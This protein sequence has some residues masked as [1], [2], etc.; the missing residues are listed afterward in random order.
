MSEKKS[1]IEHIWSDVRPEFEGESYE[2]VSGSVA[3]V[4]IVRDAP[5][6]YV[7]KIPSDM[8]P[9]HRQLSLAEAR[10]CDVLGDIAEEPLFG[11]PELYKFNQDPLYA[12]LKYVPGD[13]LNSY[14]EKHK[15][16]WPSFEEQREVGRSLGTFMV[17]IN[18]VLSRDFFNDPAML[19]PP[20]FIRG[21]NGIDE[22]L[23]RRD[24]LRQLGYK[25]LRT[26][27]DELYMLQN[28]YRDQLNDTPIVGHGDIHVSNILVD[29]DP[30]L[31]V[32]GIIDFSFTAPS[33][34]EYE[35]RNLLRLGPE[36]E[37]SAVA[38]YQEKSGNEISRELLR[39]WALARW[40]AMCMSNIICNQPIP[41]AGKLYLGYLRPDLK[42][43]EIDEWNELVS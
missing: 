31:S 8:T 23:S 37:E 11:L 17:W 7:V 21:E 10:V 2:L 29:S 33:A 14:L 15:V 26:C 16:F 28:K 36:V 32:S 25:S 35:M 1:H 42:W 24:L 27:L 19:P 34:A 9:F 18:N 6:P 39:Y 12:V 20:H 22:M 41:E 38:S 30:G 13:T 3:D 43:D 5:R 4:L 40:T